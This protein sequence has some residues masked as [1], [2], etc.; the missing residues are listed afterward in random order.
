[1]ALSPNAPVRGTT[2]VLAGTSATLLSQGLCTC[3]FN[4]LTPTPAFPPRISCSMDG[5]QFLLEKSALCTTQ[6][7]PF[8]CPYKMPSSLV[9]WTADS[10]HLTPWGQKS[11]I[12][13]AAGLVTSGTGG[14]TLTLASGVTSAGHWPSLELLSLQ[15]NYLPVKEMTQWLRVKDVR[16]H[17][18]ARKFFKIN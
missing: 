18:L 1:M 14:K 8:T 13:A 10:P 9:I 2:E 11:E 3:S 7:D 16:H 17:R 4:P 12:K 6:A 5:K 15:E